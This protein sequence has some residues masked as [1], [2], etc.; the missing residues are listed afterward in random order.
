MPQ[1]ARSVKT[2]SQPENSPSTVDIQENLIEKESPRLSKLHDTT[3]QI[4]DRLLQRNPKEF[5]EMAS[6]QLS[7]Q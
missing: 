3:K 2:L 5:E 7:G 6:E 4:V 1:T